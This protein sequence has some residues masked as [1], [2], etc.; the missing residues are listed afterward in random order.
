MHDMFR[1]DGKVAVVTGSSRGIGRATAEAMARAGA[2]VV[3][4][5]RQQAAC[6]QVADAIRA[7]GGQA[8]AVAADIA[9]RDD[10]QAL[11]GTTLAHWGRID[12]LVTNAAS[13]PYSGPLAKL[14]DEAFETFMRDNVLSSL[15]LAGMVLP[16]MAELG[17]GAM[18][19]VSSILGLRANTSSGAYG[20]SK[21]ADMQLARS[22]AMEYGKKNVRVN[23]IAPGLVKTE[24]SRRLW[25]NDKVR[26]Q[27]E[28]GTPLGRLGTGEDI[29]GV[30]VFLATRAGAFVTGQTVVADGGLTIGG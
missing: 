8:L 28:A 1:L 16:Q 9:R 5:S 17:G 11:V 4:S 18:I 15:W 3:V 22:L 12:V 20:L 27:V 30:A 10:L 6:E 26:T 25:A 21:A 2:R 24:F 14:P 7:E 19:I 13:N 23:C 29:A